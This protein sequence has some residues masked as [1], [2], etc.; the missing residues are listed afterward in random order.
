MTS[1]VDKSLLR[2]VEGGDG[3]SRYVM[4]ETIRDFGLQELRASGEE[5]ATRGRMAAWFAALA[6]EGECGIWGPQQR[7]WLTTFEIE[8]DNA[9]AILTW[10]SAHEEAELAQHLVGSLARFWWFQ[11]HFREGRTWAERSLATEIVTSPRA[12]AKALSAAGRLATA[13]GDDQRAIQALTASLEICRELDDSR[14]T[15]IT[16]WRLGMAA[17][18]QGAYADAARYLEESYAIFKDERDDLLAA[19]VQHALGI[20][21]YEQ[22]DLGRAESLFTEALQHFRTFDHPWMIGFALAGLGKIA[23]AEGDFTRAAA[24]YAE[25]LTLR[26]E[27]TGDK[28]G[29]A[30]S[31]R[32]LA[33][34]SSLRGDFVRAARLYGAAEAVREGIAASVPRHRSLSTRALDRAR[35][36]L[37]VETFTAAYEAGRALSLEDAVAEALQIS[38]APSRPIEEK[39]SGAHG[40]TPRELEVIQLL[41]AGYSNRMIGERLFISERTAGAHVQNILN[42][43]KAPTRAAAAAYAVEHRLV[44]PQA[45]LT[46]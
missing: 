12:R 46:V 38:E 1:L 21:A 4:L 19:S 28:V 43:L 13:Q 23:R 16:L 26:W 45:D 2:M 18:D 20:V 39:R 9:R 29:I 5:Q 35:A 15:A 24:L 10:A 7:T 36:N 31:L 32:G 14:L 11:G 25:C 34:I 27:R 8:H 44:E 17:E 6:E 37:G 33:S 41:R 22:D 40:L 3:N 30:G 42:K